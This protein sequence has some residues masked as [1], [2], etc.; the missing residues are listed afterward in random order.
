MFYEIGIASAIG[1]TRETGCQDVTFV[2]SCQSGMVSLLVPI[3]IPLLLP[4]ERNGSDKAH[5]RA[6]GFQVHD[7]LSGKKIKTD[8]H[9]AIEYMISSLI[10]LYDGGGQQGLDT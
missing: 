1:I 4:R 3:G 9:T 10:E 5:L 2:R 8:C 7:G 6:D